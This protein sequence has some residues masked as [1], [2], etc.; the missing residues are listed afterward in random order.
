VRQRI[1]LAGLAPGR[2]DL[3]VTVREPATGA[4]VVRSQSFE[5]SGQRAP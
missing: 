2:Y 4:Q 3:A 5:I 1:E